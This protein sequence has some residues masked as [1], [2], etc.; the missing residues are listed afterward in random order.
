MTLAMAGF[1]LEDLLI[2]ILSSFMPV[3][4]I[5]I[6]IGVFAGGLFCLIAKI[7]RT[8]VFTKEILKNRIVILRTLAD[9][10]GAIF[11]VMAISLVP[12]STVSSILQATPLLVTLGAVFMFNESVGWRRWSA[13]SVGFFG[14]VL[15][16]QPGMNGFQASSLFA[17]LG[18]IFLALRDLLTRQVKG[19][20]PSLTVSI[21]AFSAA[22][23]GGI[24][25]IPFNGPFVVLTSQQWVMILISAI[26][27]CF[28]YLTLVLATRAGD[29]SVIAPFRYTRLIFAL[30]L[31]VLVLKERPSFLTLIGA[32]II[33]SSGCYT[34]W[35][36]NVR[37]TR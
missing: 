23:F 27:G 18:V 31:S 32:A 24:L 35:R 22:A 9:M 34:F 20:I 2:K 12:L 14:V 15:I 37:K 19:D 1:A 11:I 21:F 26:M 28:S 6:Y 4:Q 7:S 29:I 16:L 8:P 10:F 33:I 30:V 17:L 36:E 25:V 5:L 3:S 13:I